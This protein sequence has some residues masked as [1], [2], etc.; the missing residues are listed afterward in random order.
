MNDFDDICERIAEQTEETIGQVRF[1]ARRI[2]QGMY[3]EDIPEKDWNKTLT[4]RTR[5]AV[6]S[7]KY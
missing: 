3:E 7:M 1:V 5:D 6:E 4:K 2:S